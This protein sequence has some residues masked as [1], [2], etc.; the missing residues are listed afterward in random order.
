LA[1]AM[2]S[3]SFTLTATNVVNKTAPGQFF[4]PE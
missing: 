2:T 4:Y 3:G 1:V